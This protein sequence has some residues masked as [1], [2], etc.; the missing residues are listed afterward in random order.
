MPKRVK[1]AEKERGRRSPELSVMRMESPNS[2]YMKQ[3]QL[4]GRKGSCDNQI[5]GINLLS[6]TSFVKKLKQK[7]DSKIITLKKKKTSISK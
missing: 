5:G 1:A 7:R 6:G 3:F 4:G 2:G